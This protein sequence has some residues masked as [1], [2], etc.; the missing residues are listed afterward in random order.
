MTKKNFIQISIK[1]L[2]QKIRLL[3]VMAVLGARLKPNH[4][5]RRLF[6]RSRRPSSI[7]VAGDTADQ[8]D[9]GALLR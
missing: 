5:T 4:R 6:K 3:L 9:G 1:K 2:S 8:I 7:T